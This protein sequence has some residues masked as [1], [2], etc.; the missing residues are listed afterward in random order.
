MGF[1]TLK[2]ILEECG[3]SDVGTLGELSARAT[4]A[5]EERIKAAAEGGALSKF[6][7]KAARLIFRM[8]DKVM[9]KKGNSTQYFVV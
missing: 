4:S 8:A 6:G 2:P 9:T 7:E 5:L 3:R 1:D